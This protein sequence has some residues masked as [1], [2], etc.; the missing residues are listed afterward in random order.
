MGGSSRKRSKAKQHGMEESER[1]L[2]ARA[3]YIHGCGWF[4]DGFPCSSSRVPVVG[5][6]AWKQPRNQS[7]PWTGSPDPMRCV[8][9][10]SFDSEISLVVWYVR[11]GRRWSGHGHAWK[12]FLFRNSYCM[13]KSRHAHQTFMWGRG[14]WN[15]SFAVFFLCVYKNFP[16]CLVVYL[17]AIR[18]FYGAYIIGV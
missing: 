18:V 3:I 2:A 10:T 4:A 14:V 1:Q 7:W 16:C 17:F 6:R 12:I 8:C 13:I 5:S 15:V 9:V 11:Q